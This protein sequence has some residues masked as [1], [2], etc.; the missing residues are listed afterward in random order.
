MHLPISFFLLLLVLA[1]APPVG[2][3]VGELVITP[4]RVVFEGRMREAQV[5]ITN[6]GLRQ[7]TFRMQFVNYRMT[8]EGAFEAITTPTS[9]TGEL[10]ADSLV[11]YAPRQITLQ[12]GD[13]QVVR[14]QLRI[15]GGLADGEYRSHFLIQALPEGEAPSLISRDGRAAASIR[16]VYGISLPV[17][18]RRGKTSAEVAVRDVDYVTDEAGN[19]FVEVLLGRDGSQS[20]YGDVRV[21]VIGSGGRKELIGESNGLAVYTPLTE[22]VVRVPVRRDAGLRAGSKLHVAFRD[23]A[24]ADKIVAE[25]LHELR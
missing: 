12:P 13:T 1:W 3:D 23:P 16:T 7:R 25:T 19:A 17:I 21:S 6:S 14:L 2:A 22:R 5:T 4:Q 8:R 15:P 10:F 18:V 9:P 11:R 20:V 24:D